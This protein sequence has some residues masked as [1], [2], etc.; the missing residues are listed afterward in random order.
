LAIVHSDVI[1]GSI[2]I[3][4]ADFYEP[5]PQVKAADVQG[6][7]VWPVPDERVDMAKSRTRFA[8][9]TGDKDFRHGNIVDIY[10]GGFVKHGFQAKLI[11]VP[12]LGHQLCKPE[13]LQ[14]AIRFLDDRH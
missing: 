2:S 7:G 10:D 14:E 1:T 5:V 3:C 9:I 12:G 6:Y 4:G 11:D 13:V 8:F